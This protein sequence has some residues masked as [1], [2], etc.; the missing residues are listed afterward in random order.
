MNSPRPSPEFPT[1][2]LETGQ[3]TLTEARI[4]FNLVY[5]HK[6]SYY[7]TKASTTSPHHPPNPLHTK[8]QEKKRKKVRKTK[9]T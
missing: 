6:F 7:P 8:T 4:V 9:A 3:I 2:D 5:L 1:T